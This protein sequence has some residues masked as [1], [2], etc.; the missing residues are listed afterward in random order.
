MLGKTKQDYASILKWMSFSNSQVLTSLA[1][2]FRPLIGT[3]PYNKKSVEDSSKA[4]LEAFDVLEKHLHTT[5]YLVG[6]RITLADI[7]SAALCTRAF[8]YTLGKEWRAAHPAVTRWYATITNQPLFKATYEVPYTDEPL[9]NVPPKKEAKPKEPKEP[10]EALPK[11]E[12][13]EEKP[14][15]KPKH[16]LALLPEPSMN[17]DEWKRMY[18]NN[19]TRPV[20]LPWF[21]E[22]YK[23]EEYSL[24][25]IDYKYNEE[26]KLTFMSNNL[27]GVY[28]LTFLCSV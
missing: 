18:S 27:I 9:K 5:T 25:R 14:A 8:E 17:L 22:H 2:W 6:D 11:A 7:F 24:W 23:P 20:A 15:P 21:W 13:P 12:L 28:Y 16:P 4:T 26:L 10:K 19:D 3:L 1:G